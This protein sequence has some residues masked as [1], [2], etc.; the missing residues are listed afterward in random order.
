MLGRYAHPVA[1]Y[2]GGNGLDRLVLADDMLFEPVGEAGKAIELIFFYLR[3][4]ELRP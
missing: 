1:L 3:C 2:R 4:G